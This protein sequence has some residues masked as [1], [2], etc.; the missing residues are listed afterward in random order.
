MAYRNSPT[1]FRTVSS[2]PPIVSSSL[3][4]GVRDPHPKLYS[5]LS[6]ERVKLRTSN[7]VS[8]FRGSIEQKPI[9]VS[10]KVAVGVL[11]DSKI[12]TAP[13]YRAHCAVI[14]AIAQLSCWTALVL[15]QPQC[16]AYVIIYRHFVCCFIRQM[17]WL[18]DPQFR[19]PSVGL[20][21]S[22][23]PV[24]ICTPPWHK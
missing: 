17:N 23:D 24:L 19:R 4:L 7:F 22:A 16:H 12:F 21:L 15:L 3:R 14:F 18:I 20:Q 6:Q 10:G 11:R 2:L 1:L 9:K 13:I 5:L 8:A